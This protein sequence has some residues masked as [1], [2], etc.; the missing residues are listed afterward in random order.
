MAP[1]PASR[2]YTTPHRV[3]PSS[4]AVFGYLR[5]HLVPLPA[6]LIGTMR[7]SAGDGC[8]AAWSTWSP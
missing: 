6:V 4:I 2:T 1:V 8:R 5:R 3:D 7:E